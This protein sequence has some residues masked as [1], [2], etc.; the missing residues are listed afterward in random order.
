MQT[1]VCFRHFARLRCWRSFNGVDSGS[2]MGEGLT[3]P[4]LRAPQPRFWAVPIRGRLTSSC[5]FVSCI[6]DRLLLSCRLVLVV[7]IV[8]HGVHLQFCSICFTAITTAHNI[9]VLFSVALTIFIG[10]LQ[11]FDDNDK[12]RL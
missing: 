1:A 4:L 12:W 6:L 9:I 5:F 10:A 8:W 3:H 7:I 11:L 2:S